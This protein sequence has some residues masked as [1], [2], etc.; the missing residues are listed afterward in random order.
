MESTI[1]MCL[2]SQLKRPELKK[3]MTKLGQQGFIFFLHIN[4]LFCILIYAAV[5]CNLKRYVVW[6]VLVK[7]AALKM[8]LNLHVVKQSVKY[9]YHMWTARTGIKSLS[10]S[11]IFKKDG[12]KEN[13]NVWSN[14]SYAALI[15][16]HWRWGFTLYITVIH[17]P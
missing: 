2:W 10:C 3:E 6:A 11:S 7:G 5:G 14:C 13:Q 9:R 8:P 15:A 1:C 17:G 16:L 12:R 4:I